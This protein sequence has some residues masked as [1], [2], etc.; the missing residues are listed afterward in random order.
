MKNE[1][2]QV[3]FLALTVFPSTDHVSSYAVFDHILQG[4]RK[5]VS[6]TQVKISSFRVGEGTKTL[7]NFRSTLET[8]PVSVVHF[9]TADRIEELADICA[10]LGVPY[11]LTLRCQDRF[12]WF[13][14]TIPKRVFNRAHSI[15]AF[16][17][18]M[19]K[20]LQKNIVL[21]KSRVKMIDMGIDSGLVRRQKLQQKEVLAFLSRLEDYEGH[22]FITIGSEI[23]SKPDLERIENLLKS[24]QNANY[25]VLGFASPVLSSLDAIRLKD[26]ESRYK[27]SCVELR[28]Q[29]DI[30]LFL[31]ISDATIFLH[32]NSLMDT[33]MVL[34]AQAL[35]TVVICPQTEGLATLVDNAKTGY[36]YSHGR[37]DILPDIL[38][39]TLLTN[40]EYVVSQARS[41]TENA[42]NIDLMMTS[43]TNVYKDVVTQIENTVFESEVATQ[44]E[45][46]PENM[47]EDISAGV[48]EMIAVS[49]NENKKNQ[50]DDDEAIE[51]EAHD[52]AN[53]DFTHEEQGQMATGQ[54]SLYSQATENLDEYHNDLQEDQLSEKESTKKD[55]IIEESEIG[56]GETLDQ[57]NPDNISDDSEYSHEISSLFAKPSEE[58]RQPSDQTILNT[59]LED[60]KP[61]ADDDE[62]SEDPSAHRLTDDEDITHLHK[63]DVFRSHTTIQESELEALS[64]NEVENNITDIQETENKDFQPIAS[65]TIDKSTD[66]SL[67]GEKTEYEVKAD[68]EEKTEPEHASW[69]DLNSQKLDHDD[70]KKIQDDST[71]EQKDDLVKK[72]E[73]ETEKSPMMLEVEVKE[74]QENQGHNQESEHKTSSVAFPDQKKILV[75]C[76]GEFGGIVKACGAFKALRENFPNSYIRICVFPEFSDFVRKLGYFDDVIEDVRGRG[77]WSTFKFARAQV[78]EGYE[79]IFD[80]EGSEQ[81]NSYFSHMNWSG[82]ISLSDIDKGAKWVG[83]NRKSRYSLPQSSLKT[84]HPFERYY[85]LLEKANLSLGSCVTL[86][87]D[88]SEVDLDFNLDISKPYFVMVPGSSADRLEKRW[89][90][91]FYAEI[92]NKLYQNGV[93]SVLVGGVGEKD[94]ADVIQKKCPS[95]LNLVGETELHDILPI[96]KGACGVLGND[97]GPLFIAFASGVPVFVPWSGYSKEELHAPIG[98]NVTILKEPFLTNLSPHRVWHEVEKVVPNQLVI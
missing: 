64:K 68:Y 5:S 24:M 34:L 23:R 89:P 86:S 18:E 71:F 69:D 57:R 9:A 6:N 81:T 82:G 42:R 10:E 20:K 35:E 40:T 43:L 33:Y 37:E 60:R 41:Q 11:V 36:I 73:D 7:H 30:E 54:N 14:S 21:D 91:L 58:E 39:K 98:D 19:L 3:D 53:Q 51:L 85:N 8:N 56:N 15:V 12:G 47:N 84:M 61:F 87:P 83:F 2:N 44:D 31:A 29:K 65:E 97:T 80:L 4:L 92:A 26:F 48:E 90:A 88:L 63:D 76:R 96:S 45:I 38:E 77:F 25:Y 16:T 93:Q 27:L 66:Q 75:F 28:S 55:D 49:E 72:P 70:D 50:I 74:T 95:V 1:V 78:S 94:I 59:S 46:S 79:Y 62:I 13:Q 22:R 67:Y 52:K 32:A 17:H